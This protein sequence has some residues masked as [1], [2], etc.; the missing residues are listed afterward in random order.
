MHFSITPFVN[1]SSILRLASFVCKV[2]VLYFQGNSFAR[3]EQCSVKT[4]YESRTTIFLNSFSTI[5]SII[6]MMHKISYSRKTMKSFVIKMH[7]TENINIIFTC[8]KT[9]FILI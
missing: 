6:V 2:K 3:L 5:V 1:G 8:N 7:I 4:F 9:L